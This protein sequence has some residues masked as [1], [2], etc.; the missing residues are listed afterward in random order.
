MANRKFIVADLKLAK[1]PEVRRLA[2][3]AFTAAPAGYIDN[4]DVVGH[5][6]RKPIVANCRLCGGKEQLT[7]EHIP[8]R[9]SGNTQRTRK[10]SLDD[11]INSTAPGTIPNKGRVRQ[12]GIFGYTLCRSCNSFTG[13]HY[14]TEYKRWVEKANKV[15]SRINVPALDKELGPFGDKVK[16]GS[17]TSPVYPGAFVRQVLS[18]MC[19]LSGTWDLAEKHPE[20]RRI[21]LDQSAESLPSKLDI[22]IALFLGPNVRAS[23]PQLMMDAKAKT[24]RWVME[25]AYPPFAF[26]MTIDSNLDEPGLGLMMTK[27]TEVEPAGKN[28]F[29]DILEI[30][31]GWAPYPNDYRSAARI[32]ADKLRNAQSTS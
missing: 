6:P 19:S 24:W 23:G 1:D 14:G 12:G 31:F 18:C 8:P 28:I 30:G 11:W 15:L 20:L 13:T 25:L 7:K 4:E 9:A 10:Q 27:W 17:K 3:E 5:L 22:S 29:E 26:F 16:F 32:N 21:I 2:D